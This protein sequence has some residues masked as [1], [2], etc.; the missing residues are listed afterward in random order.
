MKGTFEFRVLRSE[1]NSEFFWRL[2][3]GNSEIVAWSGETYEG[4]GGCLNGLYKFRENA[5]NEQINDRT[6]S[7]APGRIA[8]F[9]FEVFRD[10]QSEFRWRFQAPNNQIIAVSGEGYATKR[11]VLNA[12]KR[13]KD[14]VGKAEV[15]VD[16]DEPVDVE[17]CAK[18][19]HGTPRARRYRIR[20]DKKRFVTDRPSLKGSELLDMAGKNPVERF[21]ID[22]KLRGGR[23]KRIG[24]DEAVAV[25]APGIER[26]MTMPLDQ[27]EGCNAS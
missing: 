9:E 20:I 18:A 1:A 3:A 17:E 24:L 25:C 21:R 16:V 10:K 26:F 5:A 7:D 15:V 2:V 27:Q 11:S 22:Q 13:L 6:K 14:R 19:G 23:T 4:L 8:D 12:I